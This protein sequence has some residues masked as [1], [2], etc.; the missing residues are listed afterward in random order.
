MAGQSNN[1]HKIRGRAG[2]TTTTMERFEI[3]VKADLV[4]LKNYLRSSLQ[5]R[6]LYSWKIN[7]SF[8]Q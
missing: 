1:Q 5:R 8:F 7:R 2:R 3:C 6:L 4:V